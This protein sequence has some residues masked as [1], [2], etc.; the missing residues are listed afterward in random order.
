MAAIIG[1]VLATVILLVS[2]LT[3]FYDFKKRVLQARTGYWPYPQSRFSIINS[4]T[5]VGSLIS[6]FILGYAVIAVLLTFTFIPLC[7]P[8]TW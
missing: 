7:N 2:M 6:T 3:L 1:T 4:T 5:Y 8:I